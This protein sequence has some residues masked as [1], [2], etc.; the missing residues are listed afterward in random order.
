MSNYVISSESSEI[1]QHFSYVQ[2][3]F[4]AADRVS[5]L[6]GEPLSAAVYKNSSVIGYTFYHCC[7]V[8]SLSQ[9]EKEWL[10]F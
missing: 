5:E 2:Q 9:R 10:Q 4:P 7:P 6:E 8:N 3:F 1:Q